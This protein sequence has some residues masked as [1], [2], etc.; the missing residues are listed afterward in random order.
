MTNSV[1]QRSISSCLVVRAKSYTNNAE[2]YAKLIGVSGRA[3][4]D[5]QPGIVVHDKERVQ[6][7][8]PKRLRSVSVRRKLQWHAIKESP[9]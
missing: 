2:K 6:T 7:S 1:W 9:I 4:E 3:T 8:A 5:T